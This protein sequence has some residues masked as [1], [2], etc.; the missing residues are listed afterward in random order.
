MANRVT[1]PLDAAVAAAHGQ[2]SAARDDGGAPLFDGVLIVAYR[3]GR[4]IG[5]Q[6]HRVVSASGDTVM[7]AGMAS[8]YGTMAAISAINRD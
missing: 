4:V 8:V 1:N 5:S 3:H 2:L 6:T 7:L